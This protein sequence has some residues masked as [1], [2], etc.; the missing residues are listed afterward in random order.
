V[1]SAFVI[2]GAFLAGCVQPDEEVKD[3]Q[4]TAALGVKPS[5]SAFVLTVSTLGVPQDFVEVD[6]NPGTSEQC[7]GAGCRFAE[8]AGATITLSV[9][10]DDDVNCVH[11]GGWKPSTSPCFGQGDPCVFV[12]NS[13]ATATV[14]WVHTVGCTPE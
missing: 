3:S 14:N 12:I 7:F 10:T 2:A 13:D 4:D 9:N 1:V 11:F 5:D 6:A 8:I